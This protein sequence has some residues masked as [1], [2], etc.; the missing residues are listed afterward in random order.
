MASSTENI[1]LGVCRQYLG[2]VDLGLTKGGVEVEVTTETYATEVDQYG[3][4]PVKEQIKGR[5]LTVKIPLVET[6]LANIAALMPGSTLVTDGVKAS[7]TVTFAS[8]PTTATTVTIGGQAFSFVNT[9]PATLREV[10]LGSTLAETV[11]N[12]IGAVNRSGI[13]KSPHG[14][15]VASKGAASGQVKIS[16]L[17]Y[18][19]GPNAITLAAASGGVASGAN[20]SGGAAQTYARLNVGTGTSIDM[21]EI[22]KELRL[23]P[24]NKDDDDF[25]DDF[26]VPRAA[27]PGALSFAYKVDAERVFMAEFQ[28]YPDPTSG[29]LFYVGDPNA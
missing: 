12:F 20:L 10:R 5:K 7:G 4:T 17:E 25:S 28:G 18:G 6:T 1:K 29:L 21:L 26:V 9:K 15:V 27:T 16:A 8:N 2:G 13:L 19:T 3:S 14:G 23:H 24:V 22:A 11:E